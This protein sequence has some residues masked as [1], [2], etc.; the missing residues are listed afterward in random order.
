[1]LKVLTD[2]TSKLNGENTAVAL[3]TFDGVHSGH[4]QIIGTAI[5]SG[6]SS[7]VY[8]FANI[9]AA[10]FGSGTLSLHTPEEKTEAIGKEGVD[11]LYM[12]PFDHS[13]ANMSPYAFVDFLLDELNAKVIVAGF[14]YTFGKKAEGNAELLSE[15][16]G[17]K[18]AEVIIIPPVNLGGEPV[19]S[20]R[21]REALSLGE[22]EKAEKLLG[23]TYYFSAEVVKGHRIG[24]S[25][26][27]P[28]INMYMPKGK[29]IP[30][31]GVYATA[32][33]IDDKFYPAITNVGTRPTVEEHGSVNV[34][35]YIIG[36][37]G[38]LYGKV[39]TVHFKRYLRG[40]KKFDSIE[41]LKK[42][43][44]TDEQVA[45]QSDLSVIE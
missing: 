27:F 13:I 19:S 45:L 29:L 8:T 7:L 18:G 12:P 5:K 26:G 33:K 28:T 25:I 42:Q 22:I 11:Y 6:L 23:H 36:F 17:K 20:T 14:N 16:A 3:G 15:Y 37:E 2:D 31:K 38:D 24:R 39:P 41:D 30:K 44:E 4:K 40:E 10:Y 9:P 35:S 1:M 34:E 43:L 21:I 32:V